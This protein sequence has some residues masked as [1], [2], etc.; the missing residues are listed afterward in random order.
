VLTMT[1][2]NDK[3][4]QRGMALIEVLVSIL[5]FSLGVLGLIGLQASA[6]QYSIEADMR[7]RAALLANEVASVMWLSNSTVLDTSAGT[8]SWDSRVADA[9]PGGEITVTLVDAATMPNSADIHISWKPPQ[10]AASETDS[11]WLNTR[12]TLPP[13][14]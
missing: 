11:S 3:N 1:K 10:R 14:S 9:L 5:L 6:V 13:P 7:N 8:P 2:R 12:V 4:R